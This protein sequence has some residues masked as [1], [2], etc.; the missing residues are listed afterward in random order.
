MA[1]TA[2]KSNLHPAIRDMLWGFAVSQAVYVVAKL[3]IFDFLGDEPKTSG[4]LADLVGAHEPSLRRLLRALTSV[5][6][7]TEDDGRFGATL[8]GDQL[9]SDHPESW[10]PFA[11][12]LG[13]PVNWQPWGELEQTILTGQPAFDRIHGVPFFEYF[14]QHAEAGAIFNTAMTSLSSI[15]LR[16]IL[17]AYDFSEFTKIVDVGGGHGALLRGILEHYPHAHGILCDLP[18]VVAGAHELKNAA[19][20]A[21]CELVGIDMFQSVPA[22]GDIYI[23]KSILHDWNDDEAVQILRNCRQAISDQGKLLHIGEVIKP[24]NEP[25][26]AKWLDLNMLVNLTG[27]ERTEAEF[28]ELY[29]TT[30]FRLTR[31]IWTEGPTIVEGIPI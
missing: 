20:E 15:D 17:A 11:L 24:S 31:L 22:G 25:D 19:V 28:R 12:G 5:N 23:L 4:E 16:A 1:T 18:S 2:D 26:F 10:R 6:L 14:E 8:M 9:R 7:L 29:A 27:R 3:A 13:W 30:G 21:R